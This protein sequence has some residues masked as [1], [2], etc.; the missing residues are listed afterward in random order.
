MSQSFTSIDIAGNQAQYTV[1]DKDHHGEFSWSTNKSRRL[2]C[3]PVVRGSSVAG[4]RGLKKQ[5]G[6]KP[7]I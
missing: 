1:S 6:G 7:A 2:W 3:C 4:K 5:H